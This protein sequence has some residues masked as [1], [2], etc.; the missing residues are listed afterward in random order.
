MP[1]SNRTRIDARKKADCQR[2]LKRYADRISRGVCK[3]CGGERE[4]KD[5]RLCNKCKDRYRGH[6]LKYLFGISNAEYNKML[7][8]QGG[9][10]WI[11]KQKEKAKCGRLHVDHNHETGKVRGLLCSNC[12]RAIGF[13]CHSPELLQRAIEYLKTFD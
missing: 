13:L 3:G 12:N 8:S 11:C 9:V 7:A 6:A 2:V 5:H 1:V 10:C 4:N